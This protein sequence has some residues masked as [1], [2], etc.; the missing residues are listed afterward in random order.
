MNLKNKILGTIGLAGLAIGA[1]AMSGRPE[2]R[3]EGE[4]GFFQEPGVSDMWTAADKDK[5]LVVS[6]TEL[7]DMLKDLGY[8]GAPVPPGHAVRIR[9]GKNYEKVY[10]LRKYDGTGG[11]FHLHV[12]AA[13]YEKYTGKTFT[14]KPE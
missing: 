2:A 7:S 6:E 5:N 1:Y 13:V 9:V 11:M 8:S 14:G 12:P 4:V 3:A 10:S